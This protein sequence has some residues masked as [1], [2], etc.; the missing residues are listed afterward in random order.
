M[1]KTKDEPTKKKKE[2]LDQQVKKKTLRAKYIQ[3]RLYPVKK[4]DSSKLDILPFRCG[5]YPLACPNC[6]QG[7]RQNGL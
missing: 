5:S 6:V 3:L 7:I 2:K 1:T 4:V